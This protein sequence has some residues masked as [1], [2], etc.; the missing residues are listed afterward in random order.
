[1]WKAAI[2]RPCRDVGLRLRPGM[3]HAPL[4]AGLTVQVVDPAFPDDFTRPDL[5]HPICDVSF[6]EH[7]AKPF[8]ILAS[9]RMDFLSFKPWLQINNQTR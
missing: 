7:V 4:L 6:L 8:A 1:L 9:K 5:S 3:G 2:Q